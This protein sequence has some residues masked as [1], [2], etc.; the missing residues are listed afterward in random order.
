[1][2]K[3]A[4]A[5]EGTVSSNLHAARST[6]RELRLS[7]SRARQVQPF[8]ALL[9][10]AGVSSDRA[11][12]RTGLPRAIREQP[13][14]LVSTY[15][16]DRFL[17]DVAAREG[18]DDFGWQVGSTADP[19]A[20]LGPEMA[21]AFFTAPSLL[22]ALQRLSGLLRRH[23]ST[24]SLWLE[25]TE[26]AALLCHASPV[27][28]ALGDPPELPQMRQALL[29][30]M[31]QAF[32]GPEWMPSEAGYTAKSGSALRV[33]DAL[34]QIRSRQDTRCSWI[35]L[36][37]SILPLPPLP[38]AMV[39]QTPP[40]N[41]AAPDLVGALGQMLRPYIGDRIPTIHDAAEL[42]GTSARSL[43]RAL[44]ASGTTYRAMVLRAKLDGAR[45]LLEG[46]DLRIVDV[47]HATGFHDQ[48]NFTRFFKRCTGMSP[49]EYR[50]ARRPA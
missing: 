38:G 29:I 46:R 5:R 27:E 7:L 44:A 3:Q 42:A 43:Q 6:S 2:R 36:E 23:S 19:G 20:I 15:A 34:P 11:L 8:I 32:A 1:M 9:D 26:D 4:P 48:A 31:A 10:L 47:A 12:E 33:R 35:R 18:L 21:R 30:R 40:Q 49:T 17:Q 24:L 28:R 25:E 16:M 37:R 39:Q 22:T 50:S 14:V 13:D 45:D 41:G